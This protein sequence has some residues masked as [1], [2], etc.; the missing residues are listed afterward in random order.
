MIEEAILDRL[1]RASLAPA[2]APQ[3][4]R[5]SA[6]RELPFV[7]IVGE[8]GIGKSTVLKQERDCTGG[9]LVTAAELVSGL[10]DLTDSSVFI[11]ALDEYRSEGSTLEKVRA[12]GKLLKDAK[13]LRWRI[14]CR[15]EDWHA[16]PDLEAIRHSTHGQHIVV[17][18]LL[19]LSLDEAAR[20]LASFKVSDPHLFIKQATSLGAAAFLRAPLSLKLLHKAVEHG[21][22]PKSRHELY[23]SAVLRLLEEG[24]STH[25]VLRRYSTHDLLRAAEKTCLIML[26]AGKRGICRTGD[27]LSSSVPRD[28]YLR[29]SELDIDPALLAE[30]LDTSLFA[31]EGIVFEPLHKSMAEFLAGRALARAVAGDAKHAALPLGRAIALLTGDDLKSPSELRGLFAWFTVHLS[32][33]GMTSDAKRLIENDAATVLVYSDAAAFPTSLRRTI[34][35]ELDR[36]DPYFRSSDLQ[37]DGHVGSLA[38]DDL[39][40]DFDTILANAAE[41][42]HRWVTVLDVLTVGA[43]LAPLKPRLWSIAV[44]PNR[45]GWQR[46]RAADAWLNGAEDRILE[47]YRAILAMPI[48][49]DRE[50]VRISLATRLPAEAL[51][52]AEIKSIIS[53]FVTA[54]GGKPTGSLY[55]LSARLEEIPNPDVF[56]VPVAT[57]LPQPIS[58]SVDLEHF[59]D[60]LLARLINSSPQM[61]A[62]QLWRLLKNARWGSYSELNEGALRALQAWIDLIPGREGALLDEIIDEEQPEKAPWLPANSFHTATHRT[63]DSSLIRHVIQSAQEDAGDR[64]RFRLDVAVHMIAALDSPESDVL[65]QELL[66]ILRRRSDCYD[67]ISKV[68]VPRQNISAEMIAANENDR[69]EKAAAARAQAV[70]RLEPILEDIR[71][72]RAVG[73]LGRAS[74]WYFSQENSPEQ[75]LALV[76][77]RTN[78]EIRLAT[79]SGWRELLFRADPEVSAQSLGAREGQYCN[80]FECAVVAGFDQVLASG[81]DVSSV[82]PIVPIAALRIACMLTRSTRQ[83][84][85]ER[86][87]LQRLND[88]PEAGAR[89]LQEFWLAAIDAGPVH[90]ESLGRVR[91]DDADGPAV[92]DALAAILESR[93]CMPRDHLRASLRAAATRLKGSVLLNLARAALNDSDVQGEHRDIWQFQAF[94]LAPTEFSDALLQNHISD[95]GCR[96]ATDLRGHE[97]EPVQP[98]DAGSWAVREETII[99]IAGPHSL[100]EP[101]SE[102]GSVW[103]GSADAVHRAMQLLANSGE[104]DAGAVLGRLIAE[105]GLQ[106]WR[107]N[108]RHALAQWSRLHRE[109]SFRFA[110]PVAI[111]QAIA[112]G[113]PVS[114]ADLREIL[115]EEL[116]G[117]ARDLKD[118]DLSSWSPFWNTNGKPTPKTENECRDYVLDR[119][120]DRLKKYRIGAALSEAR[121]RNNTR[122]D[123]LV[124]SHAGNTIPTEA[125]RHFNREIWIAPSL[126]LEG[127]ADTVGSDSLGIYLVFWFGIARGRGLRRQEGQPHPTTADGLEDALK[128][129]LSPEQRTRL[130]VIVLD[131]TPPQS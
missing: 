96:I 130:R 122:A 36:D 29:A 100:P 110:A 5:I 44:D 46:V 128:K 60:D 39:V 3:D 31:S 109:N 27:V 7:V 1:V 75:G 28:P 38:G 81:A 51:T 124:F 98:R 63:V 88:A 52:A 80:A 114:A 40:A 95:G 15:S 57:W 8:P 90:I 62:A 53:D 94:A 9:Q 107:P 13:L 2:E 102:A 54:P 49:V 123:I 35:H 82:P 34:L 14:S 4:V 69:R 6:L 32:L 104:G 58:E 70:L 91:L 74:R 65:R 16:G 129:R 61:T 30:M 56:D 48:H 20:V 37:Q 101:I 116:M 86:W 121:R 47:L 18:Q 64:G 117:L 106:G 21:D 72:G 127:Y 119:L 92:S 73:Y 79:E 108:L 76:E 120:R 22:W 84:E 68:S 105:D 97:L 83:R 118:G 19:P 99:R 45:P 103:S 10:V 125:K 126:Q 131:V 113:P 50:Q 43:P 87:A 78:A 42:S 23:G 112:G 71:S 26:L 93:R 17:A 89:A 85:L 55:I 111:T 24:S 25:Q 66:D 33:L 77:S 59:F 11:D 12:L 115:V 67:L 41:H